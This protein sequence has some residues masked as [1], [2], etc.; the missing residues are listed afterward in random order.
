MKRLVIL[1]MLLFSVAS[2]ARAQA[3]SD[4]P[5][6]CCPESAHDGNWPPIRRASPSLYTSFH[7]S[8]VVTND[9]AKTIKQI[10]WET[11]L[12]NTATMKPIATH[13]VLTRKKIAPHKVVTLRKKFQVPFPRV[14]SANQTNQVKR[15]IPNVI[16]TEQVSKIREIEYTDGSVSTP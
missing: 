15:G 14:V 11:S 1:G 4:I 8:V 9:T 12:I 13:W 2:I 16:R 10:T 6:G 3:V 5:G 7:A